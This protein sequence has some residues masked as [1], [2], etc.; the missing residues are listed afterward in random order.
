MLALLFGLLCALAGAVVG[1]ASV[2]S[3]ARTPGLLLAVV[4]SASAAWV[5]PGAWSGRFAFAV[6]W[7]AV[8]LYALKPRGEG[9]YLI[10]ADLHGYVL[11]GFGLFLLLLGIGTVRPRVAA[12]KSPV[13]DLP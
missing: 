2:V 3:H 6:G 8:L 13:A 11:L 4:A 1:A 10:A 9:D 7:S 12:E 5:L